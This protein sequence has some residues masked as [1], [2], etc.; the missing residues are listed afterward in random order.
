M[1]LRLKGRKQKKSRSVREARGDM[2]GGE[3]TV[4]HSIPFAF[5]FYFPLTT[6]KNSAIH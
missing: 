6:Q 2:D 5:P 4:L 1:A 3:P